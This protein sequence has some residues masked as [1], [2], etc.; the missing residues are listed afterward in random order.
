MPT[1]ASVALVDRLR[2]EGT[3]LFSMPKLMS[4]LGL[5]AQEVAAAAGVHHNT[6]TYHPETARVQDFARNV[7]R[8]VTTLQKLNPRADDDQIVYTL[9]N[10]PLGAL[11]YKTAFELIEAGR[12]DDVVGY[13]ESFGAGFVG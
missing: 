12:T 13:F 6:L 11:G 2:A 4:F 3:S 1:T 5:Q 8:I 10:Y 9:K 7:V